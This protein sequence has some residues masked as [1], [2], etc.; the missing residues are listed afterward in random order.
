MT[1]ALTIASTSIRQDEHGRF[2]LN[3]L[4]VAS[5]GELRHGPDRWRRTDAA[6][7]LVTEISNS[8]FL[9]NKPL[10]AKAGRYGGT[11]AVKELV[12]AYA[13]WVSPKFH[14][15][16]IRAYDQMVTSGRVQPTRQPVEMTRM[17]ILQLALDSEQKRLEAEAKLAIAAPKAEA[18]DRLADVKDSKSITEAAKLLK[19]GPKKLVEFLQGIGWLY[20]RGIAGDLLANQAVINSGHLFHA[21]TTLHKPGRLPLIVNQ[22]RMTPKGLAKVA[23]ML[24]AAAPP[25]GSHPA[26]EHHYR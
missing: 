17:E 3:D 15:A 5:G 19:F 7:E 22:P 20:R 9:A 2:C 10:E 12:Y 21:A 26:L 13:M 18:L 1:T 16:V 6:A 11:Y 14:L 8:P 23:Q 24:N 4:H 25:S